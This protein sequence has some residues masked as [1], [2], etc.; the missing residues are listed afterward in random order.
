MHAHTKQGWCILK[1]KG[2]CL[3]MLTSPIPV[4]CWPIV[5]SSIVDGEHGQIMNLKAAHKIRKAQRMTSGTCKQPFRK[6]CSTPIV[7]EAHKQTTYS[8]WLI[9]H[10]HLQKLVLALPGAHSGLCNVLLSWSTH[11][12]DTMHDGTICNWYCLIEKSY[13]LP[14]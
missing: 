11:S 9:R 10:V 7:Y 13:N 4:G 2:V 12:A 3:P 1:L 5:S 6:Q 14:A 8:A